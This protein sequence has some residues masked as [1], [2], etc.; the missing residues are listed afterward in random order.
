M[1]GIERDLALGQRDRFVEPAAE[2]RDLAEQDVR[3]RQLRVLLDRALQLG[4]GERLELEPDHHLR[5]DADAR[6]RNPAATPN[7]AAN[8]ARARS[9]WRVW[10]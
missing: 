6:R 1:A 5:G 9:G 7:V 4:L 2:Q 10:T 8:A 3:L